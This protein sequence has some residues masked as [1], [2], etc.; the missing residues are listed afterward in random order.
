MNDAKKAALAAIDEKKALE[1]AEQILLTVRDN[2]IMLAK[3]YGLSR[4]QI[5]EMRPAFSLRA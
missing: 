3:K 5:E 1:Y 2:W 4:G